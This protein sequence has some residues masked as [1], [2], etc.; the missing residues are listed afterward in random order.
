MTNDAPAR[1]RAIMLER[2]LPLWAEHGWDRRHGGFHERLDRDLKP[3]ELGYKRL[4]VQCRQLYSFSQAVLLGER[5]YLGLIGDGFAWLRKHYWDQSHGG[6]IFKAT[7]EGGPLDPMKDTYGH[8]FVMFAC[9]YVY[10]ATGDKAAIALAHRTLDLMEAKIVSPSGGFFEAADQD[11][12]VR[13]GLR[14]QNPHMHL[15]EGLTALDEAT[16]EPCFGEAARSIGRLFLARLFDTATG[17][18]GEYF[19]GEWRPD[20]ERGHIVEPGHHCEWSWL[21]HRF[22]ARTGDGALAAAADRLF[23]HAMAHGWDPRHGGVYDEVD[24]T[25]VV[26]TSRKRIWPLTEAIKA[27]ATRWRRTGAASDRARLERFVDFM[28]TRYAVADGRWN[29]HLDRELNVVNDALPG[30]TT[31]HLLLAAVE[32]AREGPAAP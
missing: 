31:Y 21:L 13:P 7:P 3:I 29:E 4:L 24:R 9:A 28:L 12:T 17:T 23:D 26:V 2:H 20:A 16:G 22:A 10:R 18:L 14:L 15:L 5:R 32:G 6:W 11:W 1:F 8:A 25:G 19:D 27:A 30:S